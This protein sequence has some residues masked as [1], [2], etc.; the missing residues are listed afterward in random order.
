VRV[1]YTMRD[2]EK[3]VFFM[4]FIVIVLSVGAEAGVQVTVEGVSGP[5]LKNVLAYLSIEQQKNHP[6]LSEGLIRKLHERA[7]DEIRSA[8]RPFGYY[9]PGIQVD[10]SGND[11]LWHVRY[12]IDPGEPVRITRVDFRMTGPGAE[13]ESFQT[14]SENF[15]VREGD[16]LEDA[17][18]EK[19]KRTLQELAEKRG[20]LDAELIEHRVD[21]TLEDKSAVIH[22]HMDTGPRY[23]FGDVTIHQ[24]VF[25]PEFISRFVHLERGDPYTLDALY[26]LQNDLNDSDYFD[27]VDIKA[28][29]DQAEGVE[30]PVDVTLEHRKR[31]KY[32]AG[33]GYGTDTGVRGSLG[34]E[35]RWVNSWGHKMN[36]ELRLSEIKNSVTTRYV[37]PLKN[38]TTDHLDYTAGWFN[39]R[40]D[41]SS[42]ETYLMGVSHIHIRNEWKQTVYI[43]YQEERFTVGDQDGRSNLLLP[44]ISWARVKADNRIY[45]TRGYRLFFDIR[46]AHKTLLSDASF[47]QA[48][49]QTKLIHGVGESGRIILRGDGGATR[50]DKFSDLPAS[51]RFFAGGD[52]SVRGYAY[53]T[54][55]PTNDAGDVV[56]GKYLLVGSAEYEHI[57][58]GKW[59]AA[60]F[61]DIGNA[62]DNFSDPYKKGAGFGIRWKSPVGL[63][64]CDLASGI[65][66]PGHPWR[67]HLTIGP[68]L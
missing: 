45:T 5:M 58:V 63:I 66:D 54:L 9:M 33:V 14:L 48:R 43:N 24:E 53:N 39:E 49:V 29:R 50:V 23:H 35:N 68:D 52:Q 59:S 13:D 36:A 3:I 17:V 65:S 25:R 56:G 20:Y 55:G 11:S 31:D 21:V 7:A 46:G 32:T 1:I 61:Y 4:A 38:P 44:G 15:P 51:V 22:L 26:H 67:L 40:T 10:L 16:V 34:W 62:I 19:A 57:M 60:V 37:V 12:K 47:I 8:L 27:R 18:Y 42:S 28:A 30:V 64:R 2:H 6:D 41:T